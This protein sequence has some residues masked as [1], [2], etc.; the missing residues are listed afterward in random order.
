MNGLIGYA[1]PEAVPRAFES[2]MR[3]SKCSRFAATVIALVALLVFGPDSVADSDVFDPA[4]EIEPFVARMVEHHGVPEHRTR[5]LLAQAKVLGSVLEAIQRPAER[6]PWHKYRKIFLT[7]KRIGRGAEFW[8]KHASVL[9][10]AEERFGVPPEII[11]A[12][13]GVESFYGAHRGRFRVLDS[14]AT[15]GFRYPRRS[16]FFLSELEAFV[17]LCDEERLDPANVKGSYAGAMGISQFISSS[18]RRYAI[19]FDEDGSRDLMHSP[20]DAIGSIANYLSE[21]DWRPGAA[22]AVRAEVEGDAFRTVVEQG[23]KPHASLASIRASGVSFATYAAEEEQAAL[24]EFE[25]AN[26][27]EY[28]IGLTNFYAITRYNHSRLYALVVVQLAQRIR[29]RFEAA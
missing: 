17:L 18:Y 24:L 15:L 13:I 8:R 28:W 29:E 9:A 1:F 11:V 23:M 7:E 6:K 2:S 21:H 4:T 5:A 22:I 20:E 12:I 10:R 27:Y 26:G 16:E 19:D 14:L 25:T 3:R